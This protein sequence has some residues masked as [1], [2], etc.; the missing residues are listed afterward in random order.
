V[1]F[2]SALLVG[3]PIR[4]RIWSNGSKALHTPLAELW[5]SRCGIFEKR[6]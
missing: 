1:L 4:E 2:E 3:K 6:E 5:A